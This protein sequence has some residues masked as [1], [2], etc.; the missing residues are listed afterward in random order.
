M[1]VVILEELFLCYI[2]AVGVREDTFMR[3]HKASKSLTS[4][5]SIVCDLDI[6][7]HLDLQ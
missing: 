1:A 4:L 6:I 2:A 7:F 5:S 3:L